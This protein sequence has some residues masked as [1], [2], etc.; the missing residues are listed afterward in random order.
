MS[1]VKMAVPD[2]KTTRMVPCEIVVTSWGVVVYPITL[3]VRG[4]G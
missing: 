1:G 4:A 3:K 2:G